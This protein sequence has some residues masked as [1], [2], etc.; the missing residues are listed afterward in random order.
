MDRT[1]VQ[2]TNATMSAMANPLPMNGLRTGNL[3]RP[4]AI[5]NTPGTIHWMQAGISRLR[6]SSRQE[7][8]RAARCKRSPSLRLG[9]R[10][11][12]AP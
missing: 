11:V 12:R 4:T 8:K 5:C 10:L 1:A 3:Q 2:A 9:A 6:E 7:E